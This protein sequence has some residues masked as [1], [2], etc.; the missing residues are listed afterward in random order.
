M[1][2]VGRYRLAKKNLGLSELVSEIRGGG[3]KHCWAHANNF[4]IY[5]LILLKFFAVLRSLIL[6]IYRKIFIHHRRVTFEKNGI[7]FS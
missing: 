4:F 7:N 3:V 6:P 1:K 5:Q 2:V